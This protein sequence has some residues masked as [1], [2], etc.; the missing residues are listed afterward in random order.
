MVGVGWPGLFVYLVLILH[1]T[2]IASHNMWNYHGK[3]C[4]MR[5]F[6]RPSCL[7]SWSSAPALFMVGKHC[8]ISTRNGSRKARVCMACKLLCSSQISPYFSRVISR[9][10]TEISNC[11]S[12]SQTT[13]NVCLSS[14]QI[15]LINIIFWRKWIDPSLYWET[16]L[17]NDT[18]IKNTAILDAEEGI[19]I[20]GKWGWFL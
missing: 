18:W 15:S 16:K 5:A 19:K 2:P 3:H 8:Q 4:T 10:N 11:R 13:T 12:M 7:L 1:F 20:Q 17:S 6:K 9:I 14:H